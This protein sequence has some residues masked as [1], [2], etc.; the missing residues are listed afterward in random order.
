MSLLSW[1]LS[2]CNKPKSATAPS[3]EKNW[4]VTEGQ[5]NAPASV[6]RA[7]TQTDEQHLE[8]MVELGSDIIAHYGVDTN[9][10][11]YRNLD[12]TF[13][14]WAKDKQRNATKE[15][16]LLGLG[17]VFA[18]MIS[19]KHSVAVQMVSDPEG[20]EFMIVIKGNEIYPFDFV[21]KRIATM[22]APDREYDFFV[23]MDRVIDG[24][25]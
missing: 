4:T 1:I 6:V 18:K 5:S 13:D 11:I 24:F 22:G 20:P 23:G 2:A 17:A 3:S 25:K 14:S 10:S 8:E 7:M 16:I 9:A 19:S 15:D 12:H 21:A